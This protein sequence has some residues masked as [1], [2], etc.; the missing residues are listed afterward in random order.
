MRQR[1]AQ[2]SGIGQRL[3]LKQGKAMNLDAELG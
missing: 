3:N 2:L 1:A